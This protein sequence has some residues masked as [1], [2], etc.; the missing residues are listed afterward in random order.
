[1]GIVRNTTLVI[2]CFNEHDRL[3]VDDW[4]SF[5]RGWNIDLVLVDDGSTDQ[6][7]DSLRQLSDR[8]PNPCTILRLPTNMGKGEAVRQGLL[9]ALEGG[10]NIVGYA[11]A[12]MATRPD[13]LARLFHLLDERE[14]ADIVVGA[15]VQLLGRQIRRTFGRHIL[16]RVFASFASLILDLA[17]YDTQCGAK[18]FR[19]SPALSEALGSPFAGRWA[20]D[21]ELLGRI[22]QDMRRRGMDPARHI[23]EEPL[24]AWRETPG[25]TL[26]LSAMC[27]AGFDLV[28]TWRRLR[29]LHRGGH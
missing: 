4:A 20:F 12:D 26:G 14:T 10:A 22:A 1:V 29:N 23:I 18:V 17:I 6:T 21:V 8:S 15:R 19:A 5:S 7:N 2:P 16:S 27:R 3:P 28:V 11:D 25:S 9:A 24:M 13:D